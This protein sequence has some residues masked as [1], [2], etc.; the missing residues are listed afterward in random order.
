[1]SIRR[2]LALA[3]R[4]V[5]QFTRDRRTM[6][7]IFLAPLLVMTLLN[8]VMNSSSSGLT[9]GIVPPDGPFGAALVS[10]VRAQL[11]GQGGVTVKTVVRDAVDTT[12]RDGDA[13]GVLVFPAT[14][15]SSAPAPVLRLEGSNP[16]AAKQLRGLVAQ[17]VAALA[18]QQQGASLP[19]GLTAP[20]TATPVAVSY[21]YGGPQYTQTDSLAPLFVGLFAFFFIFLLTSVSFLRERSQGT[22]ERLMVS[23]LT[24]SE[25]VMGYVLGFTLFALLQ[26]LIILLFVVGVLRVHY[27]GNLGLIFLVTLVLTIGA[28]N[29]GIFVSAFARNELQVIQFIPLLLVPQILLGGLFF[30]VATLPVVLKQLAYVMPLT[31]ANFALQDVML[32]GMGFSDVWPDLAFLVGFAVLMVVLAAFS[33]RQERV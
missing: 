3:G 22:I 29:M 19:A 6:A 30:A 15:D 9:L 18:S 20:V 33:L 14:L 11:N 23:P 16:A 31:Y 5:R 21:L 32:K 24:K 13:D 1:M 10:Q 27:A 2:V 8:F 12:L 26:S 17:L 28:V 4:I 25:L 7:L